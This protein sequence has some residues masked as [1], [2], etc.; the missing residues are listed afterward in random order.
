MKAFELCLSCP[1]SSVVRYV[2]NERWKWKDDKDEKLEVEKDEEKNLKS[3]GTQM[4]I[5]SRM[6]H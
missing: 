3:L 4:M 1:Y 2:E 5:V 6:F